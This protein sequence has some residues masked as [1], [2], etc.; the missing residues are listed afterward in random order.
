MDGQVQSRLSIRLGAMACVNI[1]YS[2]E[3]NG[4]L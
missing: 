2:L 3:K 1:E 4:M